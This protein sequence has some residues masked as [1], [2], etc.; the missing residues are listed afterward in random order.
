[1]KSPDHK[2]VLSVLKKMVVRE[3]WRRMPK[4]Q[5]EVVEKGITKN[6][7]IKLGLKRRDDDCTV[8]VLK[9]NKNCLKNLAKF[10]KEILYTLH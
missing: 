5:G 9:R 1:M 6:G 4:M 7:N 2:R 3:K 10:E 8:Y